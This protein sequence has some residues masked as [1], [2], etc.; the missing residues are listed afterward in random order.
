MDVVLKIL[1]RKIVVALN[2]IDVE[3]YKKL[4]KIALD[5][6]FY[7]TFVQLYVISRAVILNFLLKFDCCKF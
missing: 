3:F 6:W 7:G 4:K 5:F 1:L 2:F